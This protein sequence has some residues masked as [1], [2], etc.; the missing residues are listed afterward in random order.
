MKINKINMVNFRNYNKLSLDKLENINI[1]IGNNGTGKTTILEAIYFCS[2]TK[3]F[4]GGSERA[5]IKENEENLK[6]LVTLTD[7]EVI[8]K[9]QVLYNKDG[10]KAKINNNKQKKLSE[11]ISNYKVVVYSPD[12]IRLI[13]DSPNIRR[14]YFN[15]QITQ[16]YKDYLKKL[17]NY[18]LLI[19]NKNEYL[20]KMYINNTMDD[21]YLDIIDE[22]I[23]IIGKEI[24]NYRSDY[25]N[26][27]NKYMNSIFRKYKPNEK[28]FIK[29]VSDFN[30]KKEDELLRS[31]KKNR[32]KDIILGVMSFG[33]HRDDYEFL[34]NDRLARDYSSQGIQK[35][36]ILSLK[37]S[38]LELLMKDYYIIPVLL[39]DD[40]FSELDKK[41]QNQVL[42]N[43]D[44]KVQTFITGTDLKYID[45]KIIK[46]AKIIELDE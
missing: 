39:L 34:H 30:N 16:I 41:N 29:Y 42:K 37:F 6:V 14:N 36:L 27:I 2:L 8:R 40:L 32:K 11:Y 31:I 33:V 10:K 12:E 26:K 9:L 44:N 25:I 18:N 43:L 23:V 21:K 3:T 20:K 7:N 46:K 1:I 38:E 22:K 24:N 28:V 15:I 13:K 19:K 4:K 35:L 5:L 45:T 17:F